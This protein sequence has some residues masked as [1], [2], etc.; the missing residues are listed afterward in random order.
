ME[1]DLETPTEHKEIHER[2]MK[3][4]GGYLAFVAAL[5]VAAVAKSNDYQLA[6]VVISLLA[7]SLPSLVALILID[8]VRLRLGWAF[9]P[10]LPLSLFWS[11]TSR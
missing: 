8:F 5:L 4:A 3:L 1:S 10:V 9:P 11:A 6:W 7:L 2:G